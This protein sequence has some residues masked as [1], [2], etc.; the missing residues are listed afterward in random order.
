MV[1]ARDAAAHPTMHRAGSP[2]E[3]YLDP[4]VSSTKTRCLACGLS[5]VG[6]SLELQVP[7]HINACQ[8]V[9]QEVEQRQ[10]GENRS[11]RVKHDG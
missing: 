3:N 11:K 7:S 6:V 5:S 10:E 4:N 9:P 1:E 2:A 8:R